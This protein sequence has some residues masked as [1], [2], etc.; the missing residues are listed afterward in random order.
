MTAFTASQTGL[1]G[2]VTDTSAVRVTQ[3]AAESWAHQLGIM[4]AT[5]VGIESWTNPNTTNFMRVTQAGFETWAT[6][7][8]L[9]LQVSGL[10]Q[11]DVTP[12][13]SSTYIEAGQPMFWSWKTVLLPDNLLMKENMVLES[14]IT[15]EFIGS[16]PTVDI[17]AADNDDAELGALTIAPEGTDSLWDVAIWDVS[18]WD[19]VKISLFPFR[20]DWTEAL[21][22]KQETI[23]A[24]GVSQTG[25][26]IGNLYM[27]YQI[28]GYHQQTPQGGT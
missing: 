2:W 18:P 8:D 27:N 22:F 17:V 13:G 12:S 15:M 9:V 6:Q 28:L 20:L 3:V 26:R 19:G 21:V 14:N 10:W 1:E 7:E 25:F 5:Q 4:T 11:S 23:A 16:G 24:S